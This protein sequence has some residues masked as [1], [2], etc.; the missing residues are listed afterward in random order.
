MATEKTTTLADNDIGKVTAIPQGASLALIDSQ[1][2]VTKI[3][4]EKLMEIF[5]KSIKIGVTN[6]LIDS[7][8]EKAGNYGLG[9]YKLRKKMTEGKQYV[10]TVEGE[11]GYP[12][13]GSGRAIYGANIYTP[14]LD[15][16]ATFV[17]FQ[18]GVQW[19]FQQMGCSAAIL[20]DN[21]VLRVGKE[22]AA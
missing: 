22:A 3:D 7:H 21:S 20:C 19:E 8:K 2:T 16:R 9:Q 15:G 14:Q 10:M 13:S 18:G 5:R 1:G 6:L 17:S 11:I 4:A 12:Y